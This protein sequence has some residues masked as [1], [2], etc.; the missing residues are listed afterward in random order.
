MKLNWELEVEQGAVKAQAQGA[1]KNKAQQ[2]NEKDTSQN[3]Q[4]T[5]KKNPQKPPNSTGYTSQ[6]TFLN[7]Y[8]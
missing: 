8:G 1:V 6:E 5:S 4:K 2:R 7:K 3:T